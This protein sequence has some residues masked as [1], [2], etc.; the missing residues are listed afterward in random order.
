MSEEKNQKKQ[1]K[2]KQFGFLPR[3]F[4]REQFAYY[5]GREIP[6]VDDPENRLDMIKDGLKI[7]KKK[8]AIF[9][10][11]LSIDKMLEKWRIA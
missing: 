9:F 8:R 3:W 4:N 10:D 1:K 5:I 6:Y 11:R 7:H 2:P